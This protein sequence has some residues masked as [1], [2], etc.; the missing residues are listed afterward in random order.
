MSDIRYTNQADLIAALIDERDALSNIIE[1]FD[2]NAWHTYRRSDGWSAH[3]IAAHLADANYG[4]ALMVLGEVQPSMPLNDQNWMDVDDYNE[5]RRQ[6]NASLTK[7]KIASR[8]ASSFAHAERAIQTIAD[9]NAPGPYGPVHTKGQWLNRI[10]IHSH[11]HR[12]ELEELLKG[13]A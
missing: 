8:L 13:A 2:D 12:S 9:L 5:Q 7:A 4:L 10:V 1:Q 6:K 3:D 11:M